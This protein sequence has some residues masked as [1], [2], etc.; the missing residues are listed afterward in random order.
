MGWRFSE[1][2]G[3]WMRLFSD[4]GGYLCIWILGMDDF[5]DAPTMRMEDEL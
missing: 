2:V 4:T 5:G 3:G 1:G